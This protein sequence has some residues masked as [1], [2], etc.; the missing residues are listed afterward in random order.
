[1][2]AQGSRIPENI[3]DLPPTERTLVYAWVVLHSALPFA[4]LV[5]LAT[6]VLES[7]VGGYVL[8]IGLS[9]YFA[10]NYVTMGLLS[11][12][13]GEI[14]SSPREWAW[15]RLSVFALLLTALGA[16]LAPFGWPFAAAL[17]IGGLTGHLAGHFGA[18]IGA[19]RR[20]MARP[21]P[22]VAAIEED[23]DW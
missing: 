18:A 13:A 15:L 16:G 19:Y 8:V 17:M 20:V 6:I 3:S 4:Y 2:S 22:K 11:R 5:A 21:W 12:L 23:D 7:R 9:A 1:M 14:D 10:V